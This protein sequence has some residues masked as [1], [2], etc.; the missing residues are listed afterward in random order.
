MEKNLT[1]RM[2]EILQAFHIDALCVNAEQH[3]HLAFFDIKLLNGCRIRSIEVLI[4]EIGLALKTKTTP[5]VCPIMESGVVRI[6]AAFDNAP[7]LPFDVLANSGVGF[8]TLPVVIGESD[9]GEPLWV[10]IAGLPHILVA[11]STGSGKSTFLHVLIANVM[12]RNDVE[13]Y[14]SDPKH[15]VEFSR[16]AHKATY[17]AKDYDSNIYMLEALTEKMEK[18]YQLINESG[19]FHVGMK[20]LVIIDEVADL[21]LADKRNKSSKFEDLLCNLAAKARA[22]GIYIVCATQRPSVDVI[23]GLIKANFPAR[24]A[25]KVASS[26]DSKIILDRI[27]AESLLGRG[28]AILKS[29]QHDFVRFQVAFVNS[30]NVAA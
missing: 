1:P 24:L 3:R 6:K 22:A 27:G 28:D 17:I 15:G 2:N 7:I 23:T 21:M 11:G 10:D 4:R 20:S 26:V 14:L 19:V 29:P 13:L 30:A 12:R 5:I 18:R 25:C 9:T 8:G 16:Y